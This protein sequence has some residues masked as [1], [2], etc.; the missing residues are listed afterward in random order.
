MIGISVGV[1]IHLAIFKYMYLYQDSLTL[2]LLPKADDQNF[3]GE[4]D[5]KESNLADTSG[6]RTQEVVHAIHLTNPSP[7]HTERIKVY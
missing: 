5:G 7:Y 3:E 4:N 1:S 6:S 2:L